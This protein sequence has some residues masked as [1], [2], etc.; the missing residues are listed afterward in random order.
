VTKTIPTPDSAL[1]LKAL[2][3]MI[4][5]QSPLA[6]LEVFHAELGPVLRAS[7]PSFRPVMMAGAEAAHWIL[8]EARQDLL[9]K[10]AKDPIARLLRD[11]LL[12]A[13][14]ETHDSM[15]RAM[16]PAMHRRAL[17]GYVDSMWRYTDQVAAAWADGHPRDMLVEMR[18]IALLIVMETL[19][20]VDFTPQV[21]PY[22]GAILKMLQYISPGLW[23]LWADIP[24]PFYGRALRRMD[25]V[26]REVIRA[27]RAMLRGDSPAPNDLLGMLIAAGADDEMIRDQMLTMIVAGH[28]TSTGL[29]SWAMYNLGAYPDLARRA[30]DEVD[31][32]LGGQPPDIESIG[33]LRFLDRFIDETLR[34]YPPAHLGSRRAARDLEYD[35][36]PIRQGERVTYSIYV[37]HRMADYWENPA[38]FDPDRFLPERSKGRPPH[39]F[40]PFGGGP[41]NC[42]GAAFAGVEAKAILTRVLQHW[43]VT[44]LKRDVHM[45]M[46]VTLEPRPGVI[47]TAKRR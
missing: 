3:A 28:D 11:G 34:L 4:Q 30:R 40:I 45:H 6:A 23:V 5:Q 8:V 2:R 24:R 16:N 26:V 36:Y 39:A 20:G 47:M 1:S 35:G 25:S 37:T 29:L 19:F 31:S 17:T 42:I 22:W 33:K 10:S 15:R 13:D 7:L 27:R 46:A 14:G 21:A 44:L 12:V 41:R 38:A 9:W 43:E 32:V 18:R